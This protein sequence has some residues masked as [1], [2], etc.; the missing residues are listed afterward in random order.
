MKKL[1]T[2]RSRN[3]TEVGLVVVI[4][5]ALAAVTVILLGDVMSAVTLLPS[6]P[7][8]MEVL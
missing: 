8:N 3:I 2:R 5:K 1:K 4:V 6:V 7:S